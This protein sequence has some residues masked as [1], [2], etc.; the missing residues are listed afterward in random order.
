MKFQ[1]ASMFANKAQFSCAKSVA[2]AGTGHALPEEVVTNQLLGERSGLADEWIVSRT[3]IHERRRARSGE[4]ASTLGAEA[5]LKALASANLDPDDIDLIV[6]TTISPDVPMPATACLIQ[7]RIGAGRAACFDVAA[8]CSGFLYGLEIAEKM[9]RSGA[10]QNALVI[11]VDLMTR[12]LDYSDAQTCALFGDG[13]GA[14]VLSAGAA[15][16]GILGTKIYSNGNLANLV[17]IAA[18]DFT[19]TG[20]SQFVP[21]RLRMDG[22][23]T[24]RAAVEA[25]STAAL[26]LLDAL[27]IS[28]E[29]IDLLLPHQGNQRI[30]LA[31]AENLHVPPSKIFSNIARVGNTTS[32]SIPIGLDE[33]L[34]GGRIAAGDLVLLTAFGSGATWGASVIRF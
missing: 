9:V 30:S 31:V 16:K 10:Y 29:D 4:S 23:R 25:M 22:K 14:V 20:S 1:T 6:C 19:Q 15:G 26:S 17:Y 11:S 32:A 28:L 27:G 3:G 2:I 33:C 12:W 34:R 24:F 18:E 7:A 13:A 21:P 5:A 8:A